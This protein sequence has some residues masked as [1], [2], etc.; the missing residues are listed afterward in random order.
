MLPTF[1][2]PAARYNF[3]SVLSSALSIMLLYLTIARLIRM[4]R[5]QPQSVADVITMYGGAFVG[6]LSYCFT[7][8]FWFNALEC[9]VYAF[10]SLFISLIPWLILKWYDHSGEEHSEKWLLII[11]YVIGLSMGVHQLALLTIFPVFML[12]YYKHWKASDKALWGRSFGSWIGMALVAT[13]AF[14]IAFFIVLSDVVTWLGA[15]GSWTLTAV[16]ML[17]LLPVGI[18]YSSLKAETRAGWA[19]TLFYLVFAVLGL[20]FVFS[21]FTDSSVKL[22]VIAPILMIVALA[23]LWYSHKRSMPLLNMS[24]WAAALL[25]LGYTTYAS[26]MVRASQDPPM[27]Q[28]HASN[29]NILHKYIDR[30][31]YGEAKELPRRLESQRDEHARTWDPSIYKGDGDFFIKY[32]TDHMYVR[33]W[34][35]NFIGRASDNQDAGVDW[36]KTWGI[37]LILGLFGLFWHFKRDPKRAFSILAMFVMLGVITA[38]Y[39][40]QQDPQPRERD[41]FYVGAFYAYA[42]WVG[43]GATGLMEMIR[44]RFA[45][46]QDL[47]LQGAGPLDREVVD[48]LDDPTPVL[49][50]AGPVGVLAGALV[51]FLVLVPLNQCIGLIGM[52]VYGQKFDQASKWG[53]YSRYH[54]NVPLEYAYNIL[55][56]CDP[57]SVLFTAGDND[58]FPLW[59]I[60]DVYGVRRDVRIVNLSLASM[61]W[62]IKQLKHNEPWGAKTLDLPTFTDEMLNA[63]DEDRNGVNSLAGWSPAQDVT[64]NVSADANQRFS[65][66]N[67]PTSFRWKFTTQRSQEGQFLVYPSDLVVRDIVEHNINNRPIYFAIAVPPSYWNGLDNHMVFEGLVS[68]V[69]PSEHPASRQMIDGD[70]D[71]AKYVQTAYTVPRE[72]VLTPSRGMILNSYRDPAANRSVLDDRYGTSTYFQLYGRL[73]NYYIMKGNMPEAHRALDTMMARLPANLVNYDQGIL[74]WVGQSYGLAGDDA[75]QRFYLQAAVKSLSSGAP[76]E[77]AAGEGGQDAALR[78]QIRTADLYFGAGM[79]DSAR[80]V[81]RGLKAQLAQ[82]DPYQLFF[83]FRIAEVDE[84][85]LEEKDKRAGLA[86]CIEILNKYQQLE[87]M[88][89]GDQLREVA[90]RRDRLQKELG[91]KD[92]GKAAPAVALPSAKDASTIGKK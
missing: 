91:I 32:Q 8:S 42:M 31:Q 37:P 19:G 43:I 5:G 54:N 45:K 81:F 15:G 71:E 40:N 80:N 48:E 70:I 7:D 55:Q 47:P 24:L 33:Y 68:R 76:E 49:R 16:A 34:L 2:D 23:A 83:D 41:Y 88:G 79:Y 4:W 89:A 38:W 36:T 28:W 12:V 72:L 86:K 3:F 11:F 74:Q 26:I 61:G 57:N 60:Q 6:A 17:L 75:K 90:S 78:K 9:E 30:E 62:Y 65:G 10:G 63:R 51:L 56:S 25:F 67:Q 87:Q 39:Q 21:A 18:L 59:A 20:L 27:N 73:A 13:I 1:A 64:V 84:R 50:G 85:Q 82:N 92:S 52:T 69:V 44:A 22:G 35:W 46:K 66:V 77:E 53:E 14:G 29:F 58:T